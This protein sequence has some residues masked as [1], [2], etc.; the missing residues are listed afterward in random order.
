MYRPLII[1]KLSEK[2]ITFVVHYTDVHFN[3]II[4]YAF[5]S[6]VVFSLM[7]RTN[8]LRNHEMCFMYH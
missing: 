8:T 6:L 1:N 3:I 4:Q 5:H 7:F 2:C